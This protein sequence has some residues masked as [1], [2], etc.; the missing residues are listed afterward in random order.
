MLKKRGQNGPRR[1]D[2]EPKYEKNSGKMVSLARDY[3]EDLQNQGLEDDT[4]KQMACKVEALSH[5]TTQPTPMQREVLSSLISHEE[6][7]QALKHSKK[8][9]AAGTD[10]L[11]YEFWTMI[12]QVSTKSQTE[13]EQEE[14]E[15]KDALYLMA[16]TFNDIQQHGVDKTTNFAEGWMCPIFKKKDRTDIANYRPIT[17]LNT[18]YK[19][20]TKTLTA[21]LALAAPDLIHKAQARFIP[22]RQISDHTQLTH[23]IMEY[24]AMADPSEDADGMIV[25]LDQEKAYNKISHPYLWETL[26]KFQ[27]PES[28]IK[29][30]RTLY[31][32]AE[33]RVMI[34]G[35]MSKPYTITRGV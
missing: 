21:Q 35:F 20:Y 14:D 27:I 1:N 28:F 13:N 22:G 3:H 4:D 32:N 5:I 30:V 12:Q 6:I 11:T 2:G 34:N 10:G 23:M 19:L 24:A 25:A 17:L 9:S 15:Q 29:S 18:D 16:K 33:T 7:K 26:Q 31:E 8:D